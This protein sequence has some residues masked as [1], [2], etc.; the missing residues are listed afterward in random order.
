MR[1]WILGEP[2]LLLMG[3]DV[4]VVGE[5]SALRTEGTDGEAVR[6][7]LACFDGEATR[8]NLEG[9]ENSELVLLFLVGELK[10][11]GSMFSESL[12]SKMDEAR[13][14]PVDGVRDAL[15]GELK[16]DAGVMALDSV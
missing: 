6:A 16:V 14:L 11:A 4:V 7:G 2:R 10:M 12:S 5:E 1:L 3:V 15:R 8:E 9:L 13:R